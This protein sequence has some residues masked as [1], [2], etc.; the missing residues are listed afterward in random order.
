MARTPQGH[1]KDGLFNKEKRKI[2]FDQLESHELKVY[3]S[4]PDRGAGRG[5]NENGVKEIKNL[6]PEHL[7]LLTKNLNS[8]SRVPITI[9]TL[10]ALRVITKAPESITRES[11]VR[12]GAPIDYKIFIKEVRKLVNMGC[13]EAQEFLEKQQKGANHENK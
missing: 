10:I 2:N 9:Q 1:R 8:Q 7:R 3:F 12:D 6:S 5:R 11:T 4:L 13:K